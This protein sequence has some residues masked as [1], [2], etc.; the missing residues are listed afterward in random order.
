[1]KKEIKFRGRDKDGNW[2]FGDLIHGVG[3]KKGN[4][5]I[6]PCVENLSWIPNC[7]PLDG[8][9]ADVD[10]VGQHTGLKDKN[11]KEIYEG[12]IVEAWSAG[13][14]S[15]K[16][17]IKWGRGTARF[18]IGNKQNSICWNLSGG[19]ANYEQ[20]TLEVIGNI[21][22]NP[23]LLNDNGELLGKKRN[24]YLIEKEYGKN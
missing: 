10:T 1:M 22:D 9:Q 3:E 24:E 5:Y 21:H 2:A 15:T 8:V 17:I 4:L 20:E 11:G 6:L 23:E 18:F 14:H 16:G 7:D 19:G 13:S 12:D